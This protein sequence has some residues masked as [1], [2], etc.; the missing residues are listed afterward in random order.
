MVIHQV[1]AAKTTV[2][3]SDE[4]E[5]SFLLLNHCKSGKWLVNVSRISK[6]GS[7]GGRREDDASAVAQGLHCAIVVRFCATGK[8]LVQLHANVNF[9]VQLYMGKTGS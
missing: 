2:R 1:V 9:P 8:S 3:S 5:K 7:G 4:L 6:C